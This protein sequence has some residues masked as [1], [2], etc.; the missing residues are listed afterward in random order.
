MTFP[1]EFFLEFSF[2]NSSN[3]KIMVNLVFH[4]SKRLKFAYYIFSSIPSCKYQYIRGIVLSF[5]K[6]MFL[7]AIIHVLLL[8]VLSIV[9]RDVSL[10]N[11]FSIIG[12]DLVFPKIVKGFPDQIYSL[13][14][15]IILYTFIYIFFT[16]KNK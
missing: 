7:S 10:L 16:A 15:I 2:W 13:S 8:V 5:F 9:R 12:V 3:K 11:F 6:L 14:V 1:H 4:L